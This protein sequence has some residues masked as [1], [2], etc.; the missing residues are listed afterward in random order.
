ME[1]RAANR[2]RGWVLAPIALAILFAVLVLPVALHGADRTS[3]AADEAAAHWPTIQRFAAELPAPV[4]ADYPSATGPG[5]HLALAVPARM[6]MGLHGLRVV[7]SCAGLALVLLCWRGAARSVGPWLGAA[8]ALPV[9]LS[10]YVLSGSAWI[11]TDVVSVLLGAAIVAVAAW[12]PPRGATFP[13]LAA[14][15]AG[16]LSIRQTN[17]YLAAPVLAVGILASPLGRRA[18]D[19]EQWAGD[20]P[21][22]WARLVAAI[23]AL[24]PGL[25]I[26]GG[27]VWTWGGLTPPWFRDYHDAGLSPVAPAYGLCLVAGWGALLLAPMAMEVLRTI[28]RHPVAMLGLMTLAGLA[29]GIPE[30]AWSREAG[31]WGGAAWTVIQR[32]PSVHDRSPAVVVGA[33]IGALVL[34]VLWVRAAEVRRGRM[35]TV[36]VVSL[37]AMFAVQAGNSQVWQR[38]FDPLLLVALAW[39]SA[40]GVD[41]TRPHSA[42]RLAVGAMLLASAQAALSAIS[43]WLPA[44]TAWGFAAPS[45][46]P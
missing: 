8:L 17:V 6:G 44:A 34:G 4:L 12:W 24:V 32:V 28:Q 3:E 42:G 14:L 36:I 26:L 11:T 20:E 33:A 45:F 23:A 7:A 18:S 46:L 1:R 30:S 29:A 35:A 37:L 2:D 41:R 9:L 21:R 19:A 5:W 31:R 16:A 25:F 39:L 13:V 15:F 40:L 22:S 27:L 43:Y 10:T 38:Y